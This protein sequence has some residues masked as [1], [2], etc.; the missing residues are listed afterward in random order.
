MGDSH[1]TDGGP[2]KLGTVPC[3]LFLPDTQAC[4]AQPGAVIPGDM[5][6]RCCNQGYAREECPPAATSPAD[7]ARY[8]IKSDRNGVI[9]VAWSLERDHHPVAVGTIAIAV[10][11]APATTLE[12]QAYALASEYLRRTGRE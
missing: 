4:E 6:R 9:E 2:R 12:R 3:P 5:I 7:A 11:N 10:S 8:L 1:R